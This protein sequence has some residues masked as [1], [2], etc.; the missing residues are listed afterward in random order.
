MKY[1]AVLI[2]VLILLIGTTYMV[3]IYNWSMWTYLLAMCFIPSIKPD[4]CDCEC[5]KEPKSRIIID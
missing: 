4:K 5:K 2:Y 3:Q 1:V